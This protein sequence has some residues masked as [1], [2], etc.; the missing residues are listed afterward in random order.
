MRKFSGGV[1]FMVASFF[2]WTTLIIAVGGWMSVRT[3][4]EEPGVVAHWLAKF[5]S[6]AEE[7][8]ESIERFKGP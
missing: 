7:A 3:F 6:Q 2:R 4:A 5:S 8:R 1:D